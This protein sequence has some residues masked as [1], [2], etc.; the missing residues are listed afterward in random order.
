MNKV[1]DVLTSL[2]PDDDEQHRMF[3]K[4]HV[5][6]LFSAANISEQFG[7]MNFH[8]NYLNPH[9]LDHLVHEF[10]LEDITPSMEG[11]KS[12]LHQFRMNTRLTL[13][14][15]TQK[16]RHVDPPQ[17]FRKVVA[18]FEWPED[19]TLEVVEQFRQTYASNYNLRDCAMMLAVVRPGSFIIVWF[20]PVSIADLLKTKLPRAILKKYN[21]TRLEIAG[22]CVYQKHQKVSATDCTVS[23]IIIG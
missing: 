10:H 23:L 9:L 5:S 2:S 21:V 18:K 17:N 12:E 15:R 16:R 19:V 7:T 4:E 14:C 8:W 6:A 20:V 22:V 3:V 11:Y 1:A 13:F